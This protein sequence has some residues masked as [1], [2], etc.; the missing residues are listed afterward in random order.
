MN[1]LVEG[2][3]VKVIGCTYKAKTENEEKPKQ[4]STGPRA[5]LH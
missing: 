3:G 5:R 4:S 2:L 1:P